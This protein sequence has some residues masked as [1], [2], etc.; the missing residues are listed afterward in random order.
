MDNK[1]FSLLSKSEQKFE[2]FKLLN[3]GDDGRFTGIKKRNSRA[4]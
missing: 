4:T 3:G 2:I 1:D